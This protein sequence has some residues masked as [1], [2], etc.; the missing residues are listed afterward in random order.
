MFRVNKGL[1]EMG[2]LKGGT[3][4]GGDVSLR[5]SAGRVSGKERKGMRVRMDTDGHAL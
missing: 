3:V 2:R 1:S 4:K 5:A